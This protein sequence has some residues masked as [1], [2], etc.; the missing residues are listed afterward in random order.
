MN[1]LDELLQRVL[2]TTSLEDLRLFAALP[3]QERVLR[4][5]VAVAKANEVA[6][7]LLSA[8]SPAAWF[9]VRV[10]QTS[11]GA[12]LS[13]DKPAQGALGGHQA[14]EAAIVDPARARTLE[15]LVVEQEQQG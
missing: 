1:P 5:D 10:S 13:R 4:C 14:P 11:L 15:G 7:D 12:S 6:E 8:V 3:D 2:R 9:K